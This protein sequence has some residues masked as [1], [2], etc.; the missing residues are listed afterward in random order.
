LE[1][2]RETQ[3]PALLMRA[4][5]LPGIRHTALARRP[6]EVV[7][8]LKFATVGA[9]GM[10][11][12]LSVLNIMHK[13]FGLPL[14]VA[15]TISFTTA[16]CSN[17]TWNRLWTFPESRQRPLVPQLAQFAL[18]NVIGLAINNLVLWAVFTL[19]NGFV[20]DPLDYNLAKIVAIGVVLFWNYAINRI[21]TY[22]GIE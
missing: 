13:V 7:R 6:R 16:V 21:W 15:N 20:P 9:I 5:Q 8:F 12:D 19:I 22:R 14:L 11:V 4:L 1:Q 18:V 2:A 17:F 3:V 10:V